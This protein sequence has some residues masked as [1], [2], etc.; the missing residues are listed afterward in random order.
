MIS[1]PPLRVIRQRERGLDLRLHLQ[2]VQARTLRVDRRKARGEDEADGHG[3]VAQEVADG[4]QE[5]GHAPEVAQV[6]R[7]EE[8]LEEEQR[9]EEAVDELHPKL[10]L[11][12]LSLFLSKRV[13]C[14]QCDV[15]I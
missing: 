6:H 13:D 2:H 10:S 3:E 4:A 11:S 9:L 15:N 1:H 12:L 8:G 7:P 14:R 5:P